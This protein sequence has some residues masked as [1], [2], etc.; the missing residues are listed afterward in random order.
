MPLNTKQALAKLEAK[1]NSLIQAANNLTNLEANYNQLESN[2]KELQQVHHNLAEHAD[3][4]SNELTQTQE[5]RAFIQ[6]E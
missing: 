6:N 5:D 4:L 3:K 2:Y 1:K